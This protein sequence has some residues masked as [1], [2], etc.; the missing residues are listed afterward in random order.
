MDLW[1]FRLRSISSIRSPGIH[2]SWHK[3]GAGSPPQGSDLVPAEANWTMAAGLETL[4][5][6]H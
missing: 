4:K 6:L 3:G 1:V 2:G 5:R